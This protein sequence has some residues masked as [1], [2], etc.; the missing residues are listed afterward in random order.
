MQEG[1]IGTKESQNNQKTMNKVAIVSPYL[2]IIT[3]SVNRLNSLIKRPRLAEWIK[4]KRLNYMLPTRD[5]LQ[6]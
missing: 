1:N 5:S 3:L 4:K 2:S 6:L